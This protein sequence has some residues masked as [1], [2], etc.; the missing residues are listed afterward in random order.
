[1]SFWATLADEVPVVMAL[2]TDFFYFKDFSSMFCRVWGPLSQQDSLDF[3][4]GQFVLENQI[5]FLLEC[6]MFLYVDIIVFQ[7]TD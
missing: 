5:K 4:I 6:S 7:V 1:M 2:K 3:V